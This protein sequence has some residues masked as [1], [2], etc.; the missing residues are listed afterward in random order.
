[1]TDLKDASKARVFVVGYNPAT[2]YRSDS[3]NYERFISSLFNQNGENCRSFYSEV[4][5]QSPSRG[6]IEW[7]TEKLARA[8]VT[9]VI[10]T[11]VVCYGANKKEDLGLPEHIGGKQ[12]G[13]EIFKALV[14]KIGPKATVVHGKGVSDEFSSAFHLKPPLPNPPETKDKF[15][16]FKFGQ[17][18]KVF[19]IPSLAMP[20]YQSWPRRPL[21]S[22]CNWADRYLDE[23]AQRVARACAG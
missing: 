19:V 15:A 10:E 1:M 12:R 11:N 5:Q 3:V 22:F 2:P 13:K 18:A 9:S 16:E 6:N 21:Q 23:I 20:A 17:K 8:G 4:T 14:D 7:F